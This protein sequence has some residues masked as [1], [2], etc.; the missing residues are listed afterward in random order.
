MNKRI[1]FIYTWPNN[2]FK[3]AEY[4]VLKRIEI[5]AK[6]INLPLYII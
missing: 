2:T 5:A 1:A 3:N 4:E 6:N